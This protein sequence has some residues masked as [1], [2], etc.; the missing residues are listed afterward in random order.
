VRNAGQWEDYIGEGDSAC[1]QLPIGG[2]QVVGI[3]HRRQRP[4]CTAPSNRAAV[5][6]P[7]RNSSTKGFPLGNQV[8]SSKN[9]ADKRKQKRKNLE[10]TSTRYQ[11]CAG[12][13]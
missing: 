6:G 10:D 7:V 5:K 4:K 2:V 12:G 13:P 8:E 11:R 1:L 3:H 9:Q